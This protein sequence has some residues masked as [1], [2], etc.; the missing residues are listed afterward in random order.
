MR[1]LFL[2]IILIFV[3]HPVIA[4]PFDTK[5]YN[6]WKAVYHP[7]S[8]SSYQHAWCSAHNGIEEYEL[9]D[10]TRVDCLTD[11][12]AVEFDFANKLYEALGQAMHYGLMT[13]KK[14]KVV[15]ILDSKYKRQQMIYF[16]RIKKIGQAYNIDVEYVS[17][18][19]LNIEKRKRCPYKDCKCNQKKH[20]FWAFYGNIKG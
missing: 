7:H 1:N 9:S 14:P 12:H 8:E 19:I 13:G 6:H 2:V 10:K 17:D 20:L 11:T 4:Y 5:Y 16:E 18:E 3:V 15:L